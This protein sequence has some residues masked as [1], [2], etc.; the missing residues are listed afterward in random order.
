MVFKSSPMTNLKG[1][2]TPEQVEAIINSCENT[3]DK[4][5]FLLLSRTGRRVSEVVRSLKPK[6]IHLE[7]GCI[8]WKI[9]KRKKETWRLLPV[10]RRTLE[11]LM[12]YIESKGIEGEEYIFKISRQRVDQILKEICEKIGIHHLGSSKYN[13]PHAHLFR[14]S[15]AI[16]IAKK[17]K[18][19][20]DL[21]TLQ[22]LLAHANIENTMWYARTFNPIEERK[23]LEEVF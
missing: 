15:F 4:V 12:N 2:F 20:T 3:R 14:H 19:P 22:N 21:G 10:E 5:L 17:I 11:E 16:Q 7:E 18:N 8:E 13:K 1:Y 9:L 23:L 6:H